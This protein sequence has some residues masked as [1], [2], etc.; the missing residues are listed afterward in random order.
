MWSRTSRL[1]RFPVQADRRLGFGLLVLGLWLWVQPEA[2]SA[3]PSRMAL[4]VG[5]GRYPQRVPPGKRAWQELHTHDEIV[6]LRKV[7]TERHGFQEKEVLVLEDEQA[8]GRAIRV[9][10]AKLQGRAKRGSVVFFHFSGHGQQ[11]VDRSGD[12]L[13]GLDESLVPGDAVDQ[14][15]ASGAVTNLVDDEI[16]A[17]L[18]SLGARMR[19]ADGK[20]EGSIVLS[21]DSCFSG[22]LS[23][24][25][26]V[27]RGRGWDETID[28]K[29]P[30]IPSEIISQSSSRSVDGKSSGKATLDLDA[31]DYVLLTATRSDQTAKE[32]NGMGVYTRALVAA[33]TRLPRQ[34]SYRTLWHEVSLE[35]RMKVS[36]QNPELEGN[37]N[38]ILFGAVEGTAAPPFLSVLQVQDQR[39]E[40]PVG[41]LHLTTEGS[42]YSLHR[43]GEAP[44]GPATLLGE[45]E[46]QQVFPTTSWLALR[47]SAQGIPDSEL[48]AARVVE[49]EHAYTSKPLRV[50][51]QQDQGGPCSSLKMKEALASLQ[52]SQLIVLDQATTGTDFNVKIVA[53]TG[54]VELYRP[55]SGV[56][57]SVIQSGSH[58]SVLAQ[59]LSERLRAEWRWQRLFAL[60]GQ[61]PSI[62]VGLRLVPVRAHRNASGLVDEEPQ[63]LPGQAPS[64]SIR[65][66]KGSMFQLEVHNASQSPVW[67]TVIELGP[68]GSIDVL[69]P[70]PKRPGDGLIK[71][72]E[73]PY[74]IPLPYVFETTD[75]LG[76]WTLKVIATLEQTDFV[77]LAQ[78][79]GTLSPQSVEQRSPA[80]PANTGVHPLSE[81]LLEALSGSL[82]RSR[83]PRATLGTWAIDSALLE[84]VD[85]KSAPPPGPASHQTT[86]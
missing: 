65:I 60:R 55:E 80:L 4:L 30:S 38:R 27:E 25:D 2:R 68:T 53:K 7:L 23:R 29:R 54:R 6:A 1:S 16:A 36:N 8:T 51:C 63:P 5:V 76:G 9:A 58:E 43:R 24:G 26:F 21:I 17:W 3:P 35:T 70:D 13:D 10:L 78:Q 59:T 28:G 69:F 83:V 52:A 85:A 62:K 40:L 49:K 61:S 19:G 46:V 14:S 57:F 74:P 72:T 45:A 84:V 22:T 56:P 73:K 31:E 12:E 81:L 67:I 86:K 66:S 44:I 42:V 82:V 34:S 39:I 47:S 79:A 64:P 75:P 18:R 77:P 20:V 15:A 41:S 33:L 11:L 48:R 32:H 37:G 71:P 50:R